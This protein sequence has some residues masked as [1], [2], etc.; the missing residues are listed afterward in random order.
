MGFNSGFKGLND[1]ETLPQTSGINCVGEIN[2]CTVGHI[3]WPFPFRIRTVLYYEYAA[4]A[5]N[6]EDLLQG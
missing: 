4:I 2:M 1:H 5:G 3:I 6:V